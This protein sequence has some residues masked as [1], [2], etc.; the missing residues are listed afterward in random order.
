MA[1]VIAPLMSFGASGQLAGTLVYFPWKGIECVR[2]YVHPANPKTTDQQAQRAKLHA[3]VDEWH[4]LGLSAADVTAWNRQAAVEPTPMSGFNAFVKAEIA[5]RR[6]PLTPNMGKTGGLVTDGAGKFK[7]AIT[8][9]GASDAVDMLWG[10]SP[11]A[12]LNTVACSEAV[13]VW[14]SSSVTVPAGTIVYA[15]FNIK[16][17][18]AVEGRTGVFMFKVV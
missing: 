16:K 9:G 15:R 1:K 7:G 17:A 10:S 2:Q 14:T 6:V 8:E 4:S 5:I 3:S 13:N 12:L 11:T 18:A